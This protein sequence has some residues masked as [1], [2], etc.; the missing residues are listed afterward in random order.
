MTAK[1]Y[2][3]QNEMTKIRSP[4]QNSKYYLPKE[5]FLTAVH[6]CLQYPYWLSELNLVFDARQGIAYDK[7][8]VQTAGNYDS[9][10]SL[11]IKRAEMSKKVD[12]INDTAKEV[13]DHQFVWLILGCCYGEPYYKL[14]QR[15]IPYGKDLY[16]KQRRLFYYKLSEKI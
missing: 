11:G 10:S 2:L 3:Q 9:T 14:Q 7:D 15:G 13:A 8:R 4:K 16:Y 6:F 1:E 12:L 5:V